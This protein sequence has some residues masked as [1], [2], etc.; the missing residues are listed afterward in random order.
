VPPKRYSN[1][2]IREDVREMLD[3]LRSELG[4]HDLSDLLVLLVR[5][6]REYTSRASKIEEILTSVASKLEELTRLIATANPT[7]A[8]ATNPSAPSTPQPQDTSK[9]K[10]TAWEI[11]REQGFIY[12][13]NVVGKVKNPDSFFSKLESQ[14]ALMFEVKGYR[15]AVHP[16]SY[17]SLLRKLEGVDTMRDAELKKVLGEGEYSL[18]KLLSEG[19]YLFFDGT[20]RRWRVVEG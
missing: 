18:L 10:R 6:Y 2:S 16:E 1:L 13:K 14:G 3:S 5:S 12:E 19:G 8:P 17:E 4:I 9:G 11:L 7:P 20:T 15:L